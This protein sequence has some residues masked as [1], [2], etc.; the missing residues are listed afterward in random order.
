MIVDLRFWHANR[1]FCGLND[2][3]CIFLGSLNN[4]CTLNRQYGLSK[5]NEAM[6]II[7][8]YQTLRDRS[9]M[10]AHRVL[11]ELEGSFGFVLYDHKA[12]TVF[13]ALVSLTNCIWLTSSC[14]ATVLLDYSI[15]IGLVLI[16]NVMDWWVQGADKAISLFWGIASDGSVMISDNVGLVKA[17][18]RKSF[19]PFPTGM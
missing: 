4:I 17:S 3:Y 11:Q 9:P 6:F 7:E 19:G 12:G 16:E 14:L 13:A 10:P 1:L 15:W 18:C 8:A 2:V 5:A